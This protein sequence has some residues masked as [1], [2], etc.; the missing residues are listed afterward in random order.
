MSSAVIASTIASLLR[1]MSID[2]AWLPRIPV[3][4]IA[5]GSVWSEGAPA[6]SGAGAVVTGA[7]DDGVS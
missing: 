2:F 4:K 6:A 3:M 1:L 7:V 5:P